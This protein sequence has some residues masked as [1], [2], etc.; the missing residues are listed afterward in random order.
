NGMSF[1]V[2]QVGEEEEN[3][4]GGSSNVFSPALRFYDR[5]LNG[6]LLDFELRNGEIF[7]TQTNSKWSI[8]GVAI[9]GSLVG[10]KLERTASGPEFWFVRSSFFPD[11]EIYTYTN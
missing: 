5:N 2:F 9:E 4:G 8:D 10:E 3:G 11:T 6:Q 1:L 7:D